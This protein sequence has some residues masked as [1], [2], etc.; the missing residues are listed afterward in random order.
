MNLP[1]GWHNVTPRIV[2]DDVAGLI[3]F[4]R[5]VFGATGELELERPSTVLIGDSNVMI[6]R[7]GPRP[8]TPAFLYVYVEDADLAFRRAVAC[9]ARVIEEP[10]D[11]AYGDRRAMVEDRWNNVWQI[12][13]PTRTRG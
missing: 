8:A 10:V 5:S 9:G 6:S 1:E 12:A 13:T 3:G 11:T 4:L 7:V 2:V